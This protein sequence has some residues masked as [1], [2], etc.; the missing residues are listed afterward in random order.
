MKKILVTLLVTVFSWAGLVLLTPTPVMAADCG[1]YFMGFRP[2]YYGLTKGPDCTLVTPGVADSSGVMDKG[3]IEL[4]TFIWVIILN[5]F[6]ILIGIV[7]YLA[8]G[9]LIFGGY[10]YV[11]ARG[12]PDKIAKG[13][14]TVIRAIIGLV[15]CI[16]A[17][18]ISGLIVNIMTE[19]VG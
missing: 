8:I 4:S 13:K 15:I 6:S 9:M 1:G 7:G 17:S 12:Q 10:T 11:L 14:N 16:M 18:L 3:D 2:W 19:A 5:G